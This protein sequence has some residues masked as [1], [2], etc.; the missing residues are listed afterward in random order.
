MADTDVV[1]AIKAQ[2]FRAVQKEY[3]YKKMNITTGIYPTKDEVYDFLID[4][5]D[6][7]KTLTIA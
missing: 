1:R 6:E 4:Q 5:I 2:D 3:F 7:L